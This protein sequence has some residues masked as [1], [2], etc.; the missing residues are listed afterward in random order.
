VAPINVHALKKNKNKNEVIVGG[1][2]WGKKTYN[3]RK[4]EKKYKRTRKL[5]IGEK[6]KNEKKRTCYRRE[7]NQKKKACC[8]REKKKNER[9]GNITTITKRSIVATLKSY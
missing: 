3:R 6:G 2:K 7:K 9:I 5:T 8:K 4:K 1:K